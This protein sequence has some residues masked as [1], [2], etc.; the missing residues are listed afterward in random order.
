MHD[1][2][3]N[4]LSKESTTKTNSMMLM[5]ESTTAALGTETDGAPFDIMWLF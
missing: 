3:A 2:F 5:I 4:V 1:L